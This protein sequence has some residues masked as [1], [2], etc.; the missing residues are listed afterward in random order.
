MN[1][2]KHDWRI[3]PFVVL[4]TFPPQQKLVCAV[5]GAISSRYTPGFEGPKYSNDPKTWPP[6]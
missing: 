5:C 3:C 1:N 2:C 6:A 4:T